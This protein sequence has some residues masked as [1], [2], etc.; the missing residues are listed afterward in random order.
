MRR[1]RGEGMEKRRGRGGEE[2]DGKENKHVGV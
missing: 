1:K 2:E